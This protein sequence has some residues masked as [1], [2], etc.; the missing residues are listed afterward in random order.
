MVGW[1]Q[2]SEIHRFIVGGLTPTLQT[3]CKMQRAEGKEQREKCR[4]QRAES[5]G[6]SAESKGQRAEGIVHRVM[7][8][9]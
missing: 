6:L 8:L 1:V 4:G 3:E 7:I 9:D 5:Q 2:R